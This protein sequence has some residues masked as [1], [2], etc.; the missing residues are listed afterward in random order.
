M[1]VAGGGV[2]VGVTEQRLHHGQINPCLSQRGPEGVPQRM[3]M[4]GRHSGARP[5]IAEDRPQPGR[6]EGLPAG[7]ALRNHEQSAAAGL[8]PLSQQVGLDHSG[9][10]DV[11]RDAALLGALNPASAPPAPVRGASRTSCSLPTA[12][13]RLRCV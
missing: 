9:D 8:R 3:R 4:P 1:D 6:S 13:T 7:R 11:Q 5:V 2:D 12:T 10:V